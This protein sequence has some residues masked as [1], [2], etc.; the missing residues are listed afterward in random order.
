MLSFIVSYKKRLFPIRNNGGHMLQTS[1]WRVLN[2]LTLYRNER[3]FV[4]QMARD[5]QLSK[6]AVSKAMMALQTLGCFKK[7]RQGNMVF[8]HIDQQHPLVKHIRIVFNLLEIEKALSLIKRIAYK[9]VL[10]GSCAR[11]E[12]TYQSDIDIFIVTKEYN[13]ALSM[14]EKMKISRPIQYIIKT[15]Q[16]YIAFKEKDS[17]F[18]EEIDQGLV[19]WED[20]EDVRV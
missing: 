6:G 20:F 18:F 12:D 2:Y 14:M 4:S 17:V 13:Q 7:E 5:L 10:F 1:Q 15:P 9:I 3:I 16:E 19:L 8:H 11:G